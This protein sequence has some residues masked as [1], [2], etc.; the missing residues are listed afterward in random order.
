[1]MVA[2][3]FIILFFVACHFGFWD[4]HDISNLLLRY[5]NSWQKLFWNRNLYAIQKWLTYLHL[6]TS[7]LNFNFH[8]CVRDDNVTI[9]YYHYCRTF[10]DTFEMIAF[11]RNFCDKYILLIFVI[12]PTFSSLW[13]YKEFFYSIMRKSQCDECC[14][15][16]KVLNFFKIKQLF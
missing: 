15:N 5:Q 14:I 6:C 10:L 3:Y 11:I 12:P 1:M 7:W 4:F 9:H 2:V 13:S 16:G 8:D